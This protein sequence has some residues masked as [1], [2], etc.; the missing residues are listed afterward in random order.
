MR[1]RMSE[2]AVARA[3]RFRV[4]L[5]FVFGALV[6]WLAQ[7]TARSFTIGAAIAFV[8]EALR[9]WAA[10]HIHKGREV[11]SSGPYRW[12]AHPLYFG[13]SVMGVGLA[14]A[15]NSFIVSLL[16]GMYLAVTITIAI[17]TE[18]S[19]LR[20]QFGDQYDSYRRAAPASVGQRDASDGRR[21]GF[22]QVM[23]N[24]E[25]RAMVGVLLAMVLLGLK[26]R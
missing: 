15:S 11:T 3:A 6:W 14:V 9:V 22:A 10:G 26:V 8:G 18:E 7:P 21:F 2:E 12:S 4:P 5:G 20:R 23:A 13:S 17:K 1:Q 25:Y 24:R 19:F 16:I